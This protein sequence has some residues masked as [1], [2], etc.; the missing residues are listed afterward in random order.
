MDELT[1]KAEEAVAAKAYTK[2]AQ[3]CR[4]LDTRRQEY[5]VERLLARRTIDSKDQYLVKWLAYSNEYID[6]VPQKITAIEMSPFRGAS[7]LLTDLQDVRSRRVR[8]VS[9]RCYNQKTRFRR[10]TV[11]FSLL[12]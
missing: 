1:K 10:E 8:H 3:D 6:W 9:S 5:K 2:A 7:S 12:H 11:P 4:P